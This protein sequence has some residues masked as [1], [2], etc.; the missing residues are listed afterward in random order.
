MRL[1]T[2]LYISVVAVLLV[3]FAFYGYFAYSRETEQFEHNMKIDSVILGR[4]L[5]AA[6]RDVW[7]VEGR[8]RVEDLIRDANAGESSIQIRWVWLEGEYDGSDGK[9]DVPLGHIGPAL[10]GRE[11]T[12]RWT[13]SDGI[14][15]V[16][17]YV[18]VTNPTGRRGALQLSKS[19][20]S[21]RDYAWGSAFRLGFVA[22]MLIVIGG[23]SIRLAGH[24]LIEKRTEGLVSFAQRIG[25]GDLTRRFEPGGRDEISELIRNMNSMADHLELARD[26]LNRE[27]AARI[28]TLEQLR[29][30]ERLATLGRLSSGVAH[31][32]GTPLNVISGRAKLISGR[33]LEEADVY[34]CAR[35]IGEQADRMAA[36]IRQLLDFARRRAS[37]KS[38]VNIGDLVTSVTRILGPLARKQ[39][40]DLRCTRNIDNPTGHVDQSQM[41]QVF[42]NL[43]M[44]GIQAMPNGGTLEISLER[45]RDD[46]AVRI[47]D[48]GGGIPEENLPHLFEPFYT[49][50]VVGE[51]TGLGLSIAY[52][53]VQEHGGRIEVE[54]A[55]G[56]GSTFTV[57][58]PTK[59][60]T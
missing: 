43:M 19:T 23:V 46:L 32:L 11:A 29:H 14:P 24:W 34:D 58:I 52:G 59:D 15:T 9:P 57:Y 38:L 4:A 31:E 35:I 55:T 39:N 18:P 51:G 22:V 45:V 12:V 8:G 13:G 26:Q 7:R 53:I 50:K 2:K 49:T 56:N 16:Y 6:V 41:Q 48:E 47:R 10:R 5:A 25:K 54:S 21:L 20:A 1:T 28:D 36:I 27:T 33:D 17:T 30:S 40:V 44:N 37:V 60:E 42:I 3:V